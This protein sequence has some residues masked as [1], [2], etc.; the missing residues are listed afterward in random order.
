MR[1][2]RNMSQMREQKLTLVK[3]LN[4][5]ETS[6]L[7]ESEFKTLV[8]RMVNELRGRIDELSENLTKR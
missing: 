3:E 8:I 6:S 4:E 1:R 2:Q 5:M 7:P